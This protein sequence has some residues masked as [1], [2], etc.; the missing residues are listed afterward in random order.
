MV[1]HIRN[2]LSAHIH[3]A[4]PSDDITLLAVQR[5]PLHS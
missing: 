2:S 3:N 5:L 1:A 4:P